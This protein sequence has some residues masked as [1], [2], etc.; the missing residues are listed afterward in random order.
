MSQRQQHLSSSSKNIFLSNFLIT[1]DD[2]SSCSLSSSTSN[3]L[4]ALLKVDAKWGKKIETADSEFLMLPS[5]LLLF[6]AEVLV[7]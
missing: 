2:S 6:S 7:A 1:A 4:E 5:R 3:I